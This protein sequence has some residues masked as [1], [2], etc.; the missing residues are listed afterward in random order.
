MTGPTIVVDPVARLLTLEPLVCDEPP[1]GKISRRLY[2]H[3]VL[4]R[5]F[6]VN[7]ATGCQ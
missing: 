2:R 4:E 3:F 6:N 5:L 7:K 1:G